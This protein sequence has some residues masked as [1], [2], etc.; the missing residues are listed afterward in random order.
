LQVEQ[1]ETEQKRVM[2]YLA[3]ANWAARAAVQAVKANPKALE[4]RGPL[5]GLAKALQSQ[6]SMILG[7]VAEDK[8]YF[9]QLYTKLDE[10]FS[11]RLGLQVPKAN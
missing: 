10:R 9:A 4:L 1:D 8:H 11:I 3:L 6:V 5:E 7:D 2:E